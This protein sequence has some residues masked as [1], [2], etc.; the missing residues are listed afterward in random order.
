M[1]KIL[2]YIGLLIVAGLLLF[3][4]IG[5]VLLADGSMTERLITL[6]VVLVLFGLWG[7]ALRYWMKK[8]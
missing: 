3:F 5:P 7:F 6:L 8:N 1:I 4:G 2:G